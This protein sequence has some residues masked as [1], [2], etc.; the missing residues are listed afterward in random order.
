MWSAWYLLYLTNSNMHANVS[1][2]VALP[3]LR[4]PVYGDYRGIVWPYSG[5]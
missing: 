1:N 5:L 3:A 4:R 2:S